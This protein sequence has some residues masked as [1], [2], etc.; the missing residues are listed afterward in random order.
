MQRA[1]RSISQYVDY[2]RKTGLA[3]CKATPGNL[4]AAIAIRDIDE[5]RSDIVT[6]SYWSSMDAIKA[7]AG[8]KTARAMYD[9]K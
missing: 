3:R 1:V 8:D 4:G 7:F 9:S 5:Q 6:L 2:V